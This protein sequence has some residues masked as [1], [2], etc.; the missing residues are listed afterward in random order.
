MTEL[1]Q[2]QRVSRRTVVKGAAWAA[3]VVAMASAAPAF[4]ASACTP[5]V[6][7][8]D[9]TVGTSPTTI[10]FLPSDV[11]ATL[12]YSST[13]N[14][15]DSTPGDTGKVAK[16]STTPSWNYLEVEMLAELIKGD[17][18]TVTITLSEPVKGLSFLLHDIDSTG[19]R[20]GNAISWGYQDTVVVPT[21]G[22]TSVLG[23]N[24]QGDGT[25]S[26][27]FRPINLGD[28]PIDGGAGRVRLTW[29][30]S[31]SVVKITYIA[32]QTGNST[33]Q[34]IGIGDIS[35]NACVFPTGLS[36]KSAKSANA[37]TA[38]EAV[39][40]KFTLDTSATSDS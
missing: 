21:T 23:T 11:T 3:P 9:L 37:R 29:P 24:I 28:T 40:D 32:G 35:F 10:T 1:S 33:N 30:G 34:H 36:A 7:F 20:W 4:A 6:S 16:T 12:S 15:G 13:G 27:P 8:D 5:T 39:G 14:G 31:V 38:I 22:Y 25:I 26:N 19:T 2:K 17:S 18:V